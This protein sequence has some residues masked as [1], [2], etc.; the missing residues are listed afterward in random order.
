MQISL[1][2]SQFPTLKRLEEA[3]YL[4]T[5]GLGGYSSLTLAGS[6]TRNDHS[7][8]MA[9]LLPP[10]ER[11]NLVRKVDE[12]ITIAGIVYP[13]A[14]QSFVNPSL[15][16]DNL[17]SFVAFRQEYLPQFI[18]QT[19]G[20]TIT[21]TIVMQHASNTIGL[22]YHIDN[23]LNQPFSLCLE[24]KYLFQP[25]NKR[26]NHLRHFNINE[27]SLSSQDIT[28]YY[29]HNAT[30]NQK[31]QP[32]LERDLYFSYDA[33]DGR[34]ACDN[35]V[36]LHHLIY[37]SDA[38]QQNF[39]LIF[40]LDEESK[41]IDSLMH[42]EINRLKNLIAQAEVHTPLAQQLVRACDQFVVQRVSI[43]TS[44]IIA[45][46]PF[47]TDWGRDTMIAMMGCTLATHQWA[48]AKKI[49][50][51]FMQYE[52]N[53]LLPNIFSEQ[54]PRYNT[55]DT[56][57][58]FVV[59]LYHYYEATADLDFIKHEAYPTL[60]NIFTHYKKGT[61][62][63]IKMLPN[64]LISAGSG[65][66]QLTWMD[67]CFDGVLPTPRHGCAVEINALWFNTLAIIKHF[68]Q[69][70][71][72]EQPEIPVLMILV[73]G[74]FNTLF[75]NPLAHC[76]YDYIDDL[77]IPNAQ[78][79]PNQA[80]AIGLPFTLLEPSIAHQVLLNVH[81][82][83]YTPLGL[84]TLAMTDKEFKPEHKGSHYDR[85][86][87]YHQGT[88]WPFLLGVYFM[89]IINHYEKDSI[90]FK[91]LERQLTAW[92]NA[93][94]EGCIGQMAEIYDGDSPSISRGCFAQAWSASEALRV[95]KAYEKRLAQ[96]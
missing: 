17:A 78:I 79:R 35:Q 57:L 84:R 45:G 2:K 68:N 54:E 80:F 58:L 31:M 70:L 52:R 89:S 59:S 22:H 16:F 26:L 37:E 88:V 63:H 1:S 43:D 55:V 62:H 86:M 33:R 61:D 60:Q 69:L 66:D 51:T 50:R 53:G 14:S 83:L 91:Q 81:Q 21:K 11:Y 36:A 41:S 7:L 90:L 20:I 9:S 12:T 40:T 67:V 25:K 5:N 28:L 87:A 19:Q 13:L 92:T 30:R 93:L 8:F 95:L 56:S 24:P 76:L 10:N 39:H 47:F 34:D 71:Q 44:T 6:L 49:F 85:D 73:K 46:Y 42:K 64:G 18:Y 48:T 72:I 74:S 29:Q 75:Y 65:I 77:G 96:P 15:N 3:V 38:E 27:H 23:P 94:H 82:H 4:L 32:I